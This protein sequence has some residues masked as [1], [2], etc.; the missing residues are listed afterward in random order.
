MIVAEMVNCED[1][2]R[3]YDDLISE[4]SSGSREELC[5]SSTTIV[6]ALLRNRLTKF[7]VEIPSAFI[8]EEAEG[9]LRDLRECKLALYCDVVA[10]LLKL[11]PRSLPKLQSTFALRLGDLAAPSAYARTLQ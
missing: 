4:L 5:R 10:T 1:K 8:A 6:P 11:K 7:F 2:T 3:R 9:P